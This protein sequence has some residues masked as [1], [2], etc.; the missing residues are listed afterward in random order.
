ME[1]SR[2]SARVPVSIRVTRGASESRIVPGAMSTRA[3][4]PR[5]LS[6]VSQISM[7]EP[8]ISG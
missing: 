6:F 2:G 3:K 8:I 4:T 5:P 7:R 1:A